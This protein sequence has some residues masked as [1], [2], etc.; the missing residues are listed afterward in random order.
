MEPWEKDSVATLPW[1]NDKPAETDPVGELESEKTLKNLS[2][3][4]G[5]FD[6]VGAVETAATVASAFAN[7]AVRG[8]AGIG[9]TVVGAWPGG[10]S[11]NE[12]ANQ[13]LE[14]IPDFTYEPRTEGGATG[15]EMVGAAGQKAID[16]AKF[17][18]SGYAGIG[19]LPG[20]MDEAARGVRE[21]QET[22]DALA[23]GVFEVTGSPALATGT[24]LLP[25]VA[26]AGF[27]PGKAVSRLARTDTPRMTPDLPEPGFGGVGTPDA[28]PVR[29]S[30]PEPTVIPKSAF[31]ELSAAIRDGDKQKIL[32]MVNANPVIVAAFDELGIE[33]TPAMV[34]DNAA[35]RQIEAGLASKAD[36]GLPQAHELA[37]LKLNEQARQLVDDAG[38]V[39]G[40]PAQT[41]ARIEGR[42]D[43]LHARY[44]DDTEK[45]WD[46]L[47]TVIPRG[48]RIDIKSAA[49]EI[50]EEA[51]LAGG[52][53]VGVGLRHLSKHEREL[54]DM[55]FRK[56]TVDGKTTWE[57]QEPTYAAVDRYRKR[58]G[59]GMENRGPFNDATTA[60]LDH[61]YGQMADAQ[62]RVAQGNGYGDLWQRGNQLVQGRKAL[63]QSIQ[64]T[65]G[66]NLNQSAV[67]RINAA[68]NSLL[69][70]DVKK[71]DQL[72]ADIPP[73]LR[74]AAAAQSLEGILFTAGKNTK[75]SQSIVAN[76][77]RIKSSPAVRQRLLGEL[78]EEAQATFM[79]IGE[80]ATGFYRAMEKLNRSNT[81]NAAQVIKSIE[82]PGFMNRILGGAAEKGTTRVPVVGE[83]M[84]TLAGR[85]PEAKSAGAMSR[86]KA[87]AD[88]LA[89]PA[90]HRA[91]V[92][93]AQGNVK[94][95]NQIL[96]SS[97]TY[98]QWL[99]TRPI[100]ERNRIMAAGITALFDEDQE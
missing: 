95:A 11:P 28:P 99:K 55:A 44:L 56:K 17:V 14:A 39:A 77:N 51:R 19:A 94:K 79:S 22:P 24:K 72:M 86:L 47:S 61:L 84:R 92:Q 54:F 1:E 27:V 46:E 70:G 97:Q 71:W 66:R 6:P 5:R 53:N 40:D 82:Q 75:M 8:I 48:S 50:L 9:G 30:A 83:W 85:T 87:G 45:V 59:M 67:T 2:M 42:Y 76:F 68:A 93:Y 21:F 13:W 89:D 43:E 32:E 4:G 62:G 10:M 29:P 88:M 37:E 18:G 98:M 26:S 57:Y 41:A 7:E 73:E 58:L 65:L 63:E 3:F 20:G 31:D 60:D 35:L 36:S 78:S 25:E 64:R 33:F 69:K 80:A 96:R 100:P 49:D 23:E 52:G 34:S 74:A 16:V 15:V 81:T 12:R 90:M 38:G 91:I